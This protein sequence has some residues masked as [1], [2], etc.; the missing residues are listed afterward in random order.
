MALGYDADCNAATAGTVVGAR[1]GYRHIAALPQFRMPDRYLN[2]TRPQLPTECRIRDQAETL[3]RLA[4]RVILAQGGACL[5]VAGEPGFL[6]RLQ[7]P[8]LQEA[9]PPNPRGPATRP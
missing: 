4:E 5:T 1:W 7:A 8:R 3:L 2:K 6:I 9:L